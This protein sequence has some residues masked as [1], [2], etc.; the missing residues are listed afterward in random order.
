MYLI[1][2]EY[3]ILGIDGFIKGPRHM[4]SQFRLNCFGLNIAIMWGDKDPDGNGIEVL[5]GFVKYNVW[6]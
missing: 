3:L 4:G 5:F 6:L 1:F 2:K